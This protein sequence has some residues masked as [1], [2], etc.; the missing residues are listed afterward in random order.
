M[1]ALR[2]AVGDQPGLP[3]YPGDYGPFVRAFAGHVAEVA[4][5]L[6][7]Q[8]ED[9]GVRF[10]GEQAARDLPAMEVGTR[11]REDNSGNGILGERG[12]G[13]SSCM[14]RVVLW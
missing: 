4:P 2:A 11:G 9:W 13:Q 3:P 5:G 14:G 12:Q 7:V 6:G 10:T 1:R 8:L